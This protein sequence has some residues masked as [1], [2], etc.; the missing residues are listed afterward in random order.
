M[1]RLGDNNSIEQEDDLDVVV[2]DYVAP[3]A[4]TTVRIVESVTLT[5]CRPNSDASHQ[6]RFFLVPK[7]LLN[8]DALLGF[9]DSGEGHSGAYTC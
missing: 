5:W 2:P 4:Q 8:T 3:N 1:S 9:M 6:T 7:D